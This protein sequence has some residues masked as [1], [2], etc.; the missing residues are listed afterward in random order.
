M[1]LHSPLSLPCSFAA[2]PCRHLSLYILSWNHTY[3]TKPISSRVL[4]GSRHSQN[5]VAQIPGKF[6]SF[7]MI[8]T[9][10]HLS[11]TWS[12]WHKNG[13]KFV[14]R[15]L[16][17][18]GKNKLNGE[19]SKDSKTSLWRLQSRTSCDLSPPLSPQRLHP[20]RFTYPQIVALI[21]LYCNYLIKN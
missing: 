12:S 8:E 14:L 4:E 10:L 9:K 19:W 5:M 17:I 11:G 16:K 3:R 1:W 6:C 15:F 20:T 18:F 2:C 7:S 21:T 13:C